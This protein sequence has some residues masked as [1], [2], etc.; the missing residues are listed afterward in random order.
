MARNLVSN[1]PLRRFATAIEAAPI[2]DA[3]GPPPLKDSLR[4]HDE[5]AL[6]RLGQSKSSIATA[7]GRWTKIASRPQAGA[8][9]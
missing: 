6:S 7:S 1:G 3:R 4:L 8:R 5:A 9:S 2:E